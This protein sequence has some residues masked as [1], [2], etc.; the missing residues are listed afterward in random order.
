MSDSNFRRPRSQTS[1]YSNNY[2][3]SRGSHFHWNPH[4]R[5]EEN[6]EMEQESNQNLHAT[7]QQ[8][9]LSSLPIASHQQHMF[10]S[11]EQF[12]SEHMKKSNE[13]QKNIRPFH[14]IENHLP[15]RMWS[16]TTDQEYFRR[17]HQQYFK[18]HLICYNI[19]S[20]TL[21]E[22]NKFLY[23]N[24]LRNNLKWYRRKDR[25]LR[26]LLR[27][28]ADILCLQE[29]ENYH[30][31]HDI[32]PNLMQNGYDS[33][34][35][36]RT[37]DKSDGCCIFYKI[38]RLKLIESKAVS[39]YQKD[40]RVLDRDNCGLIALFQPISSKVSSDDIFCVATTHLLFSPKRGD[41]KL[42]QIQY[43]L[44]EIDR[45]ATKDSYTNSYYPIILC[46]D[47]NSHPQS[48]LIQFLLN[49]Y[50]KYDSYRCIEISGQT[51]NSIIKNCFS[52]QLPSNELL[53]SSFVTS[54]CRLAI[55]NNESNFQTHINQH[56]SAILTHNK[57]FQSVYDLN[58]S[59]DITT[60]SGD[61]SKLV[62]YIFYT[63]QENN[64][65][66]LNL[67]SRFDLYKQNQ[68][69]DIHIPNHQFASDHFLLAAKFALKINHDK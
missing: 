46:G 3:S 20:Q 18:F 11:Q 23:V 4:F 48:P 6:N 28:D 58:N 33:I 65:S 62:D 8:S 19:L 21:L 47:F 32:R 41:I 56:S 13:H 64:P 25:L 54:D 29:M 50:I 24:C 35:L 44:A 10:T 68:M 27:Q 60:N 45:L 49:Q 1:Y 53:P 59:L 52:Y 38:N 40:I 31:E 22:D 67:L 14:H 43:F 12:S 2:R 7:Y 61:E 39:F 5:H 66:K 57:K 63:Q 42:A 51:E 30:Y 15:Y 36:K 37:G 34:Y 55:S 26:E 17:Y 69:I 9:S 16:N